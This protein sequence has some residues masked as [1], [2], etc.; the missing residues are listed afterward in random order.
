[1][2]LVKTNSELTSK[3]GKTTECLNSV[4]RKM[5]LLNVSVL[6]NREY[7]NPFDIVVYRG[8]VEEIMDELASLDIVSNSVRILIEGCEHILDLAEVK[9]K[10]DSCCILGEN[11]EENLNLEDLT[12][13]MVFQ[14]ESLITTRGVRKFNVEALGPIGHASLEAL[15]ILKNKYNLSVTIYAP[16]RKYQKSWIFDYIK[17]FEVNSCKKI[18]GTSSGTVIEDRLQPVIQSSKFCIVWKKDSNEIQ[19]IET[20]KDITA[21]SY[22]I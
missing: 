1:M 17:D 2:N 5:E 16:N 11:Y 14:L 13:R 20:K 15:K 9:Y 7:L 22:I 6:Q 19:C 12:G 8:I 18:S 21:S 4:T 3:L 10:D